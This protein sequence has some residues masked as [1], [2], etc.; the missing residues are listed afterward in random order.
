MR[1]IRSISSFHCV[2]IAALSALLSLA[3]PA[4][5]EVYANGT[6]KVLRTGW[7]ADSFGI[8]LNA[9]QQNPAGCPNALGYVSDSSLPGYK[10]YYAAALA[11]YQTGKMISVVID[12]NT[13]VCVMGY[14]KIIGINLFR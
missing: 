3:Q 13:G 8:E 11:A 4:Q 14:P 9:P 1:M 2:A 5:A 7:N 6:I 10:T 12:S